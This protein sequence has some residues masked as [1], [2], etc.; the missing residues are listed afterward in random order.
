MSIVS[1]FLSIVALTFLALAPADS[2][3]QPDM[4]SEPVKA[5][6]LFAVQV[7]TGPTWDASKPPHEQL[8]FRDH[9]ANLKR[10][11]D[12]GHLIVGARYSDLGLI[13]LAAESEAQ[14]RSMM[15]GD[16]SFEAGI[17][18]YEVHPF[19]VFYPGTLNAVP[20]KTAK[21]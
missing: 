16:P 12:A 14:V 8:H 4:A 18:R 7:R 15:D 21:Q 17:F 19:N 3:A 20:R 6:P 1:R 11:R 9:S 13:I 5:L 10:L 2:V